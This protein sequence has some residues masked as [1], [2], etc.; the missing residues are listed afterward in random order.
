MFQHVLGV[1]PA[2][3]GSKGVTRK[4]LRQVGGRSLVA[5]AIRT[6]AESTRLT[7]FVTTTDDDEIASAAR[8]EGSPVRRRPSELATD[9]APMALTVLD[10]LNS[11]EEECGLVFDAVVLLQPTS[12]LRRGSDVDAA[13]ELLE[14][15]DRADCA[16]SV[17]QVEDVHPA[18]M[19]RLVG[20]RSM[21]PLWPEWETAQRQD[22]PPLYYRN[23]A[24]YVTRRSTLVGR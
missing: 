17:C 18:R 2:R 6:A 23:G 15:D 3:G 16:I 21:H 19:Y 9:D 14:Q 5:H 12:P 22:L 8:E 4:N 20:R 24:V 1:I 11:A 13:V 10:A 7:R